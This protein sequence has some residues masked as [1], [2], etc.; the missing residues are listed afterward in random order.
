[1]ERPKKP[2]LTYQQRQ[3]SNGT[4]VTELTAESEALWSTYLRE[5]HFARAALYRSLHAK[6]QTEVPNS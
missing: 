2:E 5:D 6:K 3:E 4:I 1:M